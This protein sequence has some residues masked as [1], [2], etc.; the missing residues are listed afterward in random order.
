[1][2]YEVNSEIQSQLSDCEEMKFNFENGQNKDDARN[3]EPCMIQKNVSSFA[4]IMDS[5]QIYWSG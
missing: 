4:N 1:M 5:S 3:F 2:D